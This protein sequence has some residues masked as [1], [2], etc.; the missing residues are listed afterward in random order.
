[1]TVVPVTRGT[2]RLRLE[3]MARK[4]AHLEQAT[5]GFAEEQ[6][7]WIDR[8]AVDGMPTATVRVDPG[9]SRRPNRFD[10]EETPVTDDVRATDGVLVLC[11]TEDA[12]EAWLR[13]GEVLCRLWA[14]AMDAG[15]SLVPLSQPIE[16]DRTRTELAELLAQRGHPQLVVRIGWQEISR[17]PLPPTPRRPL[18]EVLTT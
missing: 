5:P 18:S 13:T 17:S 12:P 14:R 7:A 16:V 11:T 6:H 15:L 4:A 10:P 3:L 2:D 8:S 1:M 9:R